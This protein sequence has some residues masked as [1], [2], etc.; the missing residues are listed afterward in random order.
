MRNKNLSLLF[1]TPSGVCRRNS[2]ERPLGSLIFDQWIRAKNVYV[3]CFRQIVTLVFDLK[4]S[5]RFA[6]CPQSSCAFT[7][8]SKAWLVRLACLDSG[9]HRPSD[10]IEKVVQIEISSSIQPNACSLFHRVINCHTLAPQSPKKA[11]AVRSG[12]QHQ[13]GVAAF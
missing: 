8:E 6:L 5:F 13:A 9:L 12:R 1:A 11:P 3:M 7:A 4:R 10:G 2:L